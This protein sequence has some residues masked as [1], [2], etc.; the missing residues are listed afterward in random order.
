[1]RSLREIIDPAPFWV[2]EDMPVARVAAA[3][4][5][6]Q[7]D[8]APVV[9]RGGRLIGMVSTT[10]LAQHY[11]GDEAGIARDAMTA[12]L[13]HYRHARIIVLNE[14]TSAADAALAMQT[15]DVGC[16]LVSGGG[17]G[18]VGIVTDRDLA[19]RVVGAGREPR[20]TSLGEVMSSPVALLDVKAPHEMALEVMRKGRIRR[21]PLVDGARVVGMVTLDDLLI[22]R[23]ATHDEVARIV[24]DQIVHTGPAS[25]RRYDEWT[26]LARRHS[27][28]LGTKTKLVSDV[29]IAADLRSKKQAERA[30]EIILDALAAA[31]DAG[32]R[33]RFVAR[34]PVAFHDRL[35]DHPD[36]AGRATS[37]GELDELMAAELGTDRERA[38][39]I[40]DAVGQTLTRFV[41]AADA[42]GR[43]L[44]HDL[45]GLVASKSL[46]SNNQKDDC[47][48][49][50]A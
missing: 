15:N 37:R 14:S 23:T 43:T 46:P 32:V 10:D 25:T 12:S 6:R 22:E 40:A 47:H 11:S 41:H 7:L 13:E 29:R 18:I 4:A 30:L 31:V 3:L 20:S 24:Q 21:V 16:I 44:P 26:A 36:G 48:D 38:A 9:T 34:F 28:A 39:R 17:G 42:V 49:D 33:D 2:P 5:E 35:R 50:S 27:R 19:I 1:M 8:A 45:R